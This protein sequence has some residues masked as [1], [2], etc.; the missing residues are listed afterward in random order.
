[1]HCCGIAQQQADQRADHRQVQGA[2]KDPEVDGLKEP[3]EILQRPG[4]PALGGNREGVIQ[5]EQHGHHRKE[6]HPDDIGREEK[7]LHYALTFFMMWIS[8]GS[9]PNPTM[10]P[11]GSMRVECTSH[12]VPSAPST[13]IS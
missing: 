13:I 1:D 9:R 6:H 10:V 5:H 2:D 7:P 4:G 8:M 12:S 11:T 3:S